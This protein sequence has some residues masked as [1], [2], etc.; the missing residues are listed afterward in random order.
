MVAVIGSRA[1]KARAAALSSNL[2]VNA[3]EPMEMRIRLP[4]EGS[5]SGFGS[6]SGAGSGRGFGAGV[7]VPG[8]AVP[9]SGLQAV[10]ADEAERA[11][12]VMLRMNMR[13][14]ALRLLIFRFG[15]GR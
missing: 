6:G 8:F 10:N 14:M 9:S 15:S 3:A 1:L 4:A 7:A 11:K 13:F 2:A 12:S 5:G